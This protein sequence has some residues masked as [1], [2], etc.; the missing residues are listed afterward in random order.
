MHAYIMLFR[1]ASEMVVMVVEE[2][3]I[4]SENVQFHQCRPVKEEILKTMEI[5]DNHIISVKVIADNFFS[6]WAK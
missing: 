6:T 3:L 4:Y 2:T 5:L 1:I